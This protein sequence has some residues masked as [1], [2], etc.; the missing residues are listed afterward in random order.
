[1]DSS[2]D[3]KP[4]FGR[5]RHDLGLELIG[6]AI[7]SLVG[8]FLIDQF[9]LTFRLSQYFVVFV[10][11]ITGSIF[12]LY[13]RFKSIALRFAPL[14][15]ISLFASLLANTLSL[16]QAFGIREVP[17]QA[18]SPYIVAYGGAF[19]DNE[20]TEGTSS[21]VM[22]Y[23]GPENITYFVNYELPKN[24]NK[25]VW[26]GITFQFPTGLDMTQ[27]D[28]I[29]LVI[30]FSG[31]DANCSLVITD[32]DSSKEINLKDISSSK[33]VVITE[34]ENRR[35][36]NV[37]LDERLLLFRPNSIKEIKFEANA[38]SPRGIHSFY[39]SNIDLIKP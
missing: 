28:A 36:V 16:F 12:L 21:F 3:G 34:V 18:S 25:K 7:V 22:K 14:I 35:V 6:A 38:G 4:V 29:E 8:L 15:L 11:F 30:S 9:G 24:D 39:I 19:D 2:D 10:L 5:I 26:A 32:G 23:D 20:E 13:G 1:M 27:Y 33:Y 37:K 17:I 31:A